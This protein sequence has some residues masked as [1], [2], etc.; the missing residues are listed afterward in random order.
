M[1]AG[2]TSG[3]ERHNAKERSEVGNRKARREK[4]GLA[5]CEEVGNTIRGDADSHIFCVEKYAKEHHGCG[6][7]TVLVQGG[8]EA[9]VEEQVIKG[10]ECLSGICRNFSAPKVVDVVRTGKTEG[11]EHESDS[12][13]GALAHH[14]G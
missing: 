10:I 14:R 12:R 4:S 3:N 11:T 2:R 9:K 8:L 5:L 1:R 6:G 13:C 7:R